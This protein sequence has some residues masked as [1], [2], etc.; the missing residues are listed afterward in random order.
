MD[1]PA[2]AVALP[3]HVFVKLNVRPPVL[4]ETTY[5][6]W[7]LLDPSDRRIDQIQYLRDIS[8]V[9]LLGRFFYNQGITHAQQAEF[10]TRRRSRKAQLPIRSR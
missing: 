5:P 4:V 10:R 7:T 6:N 1:V 2:Q 9:A 3:N 8:D